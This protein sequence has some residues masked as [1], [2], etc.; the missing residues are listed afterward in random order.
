[1]AKS[2][3]VAKLV[4]T[5][6]NSST[7]PKDAEGKDGEDMGNGNRWKKLRTRIGPFNVHSI[8]ILL[9]MDSSGDS[10]SDRTAKQTPVSR[11]S[12]KDTV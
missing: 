11:G 7:L 4:T 1:M 6:V 9:S 8:R 12:D 5:A 3:C 2:I 10:D